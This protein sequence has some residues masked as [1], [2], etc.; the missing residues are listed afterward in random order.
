M[1]NKLNYLSEYEGINR[2]EDGLT[3]YC[4]TVELLDGSE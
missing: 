1:K 4:L 3:R 2:K